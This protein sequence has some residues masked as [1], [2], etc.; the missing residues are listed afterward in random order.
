MHS[1]KQ[2]GTIL[3]GAVILSLSSLVAKILS[4]L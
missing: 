1:E 3:K 2:M 4:D